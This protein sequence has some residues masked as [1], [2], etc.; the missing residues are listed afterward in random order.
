[1]AGESHG[2]RWVVRCECDACD[3]GCGMDGVCMCRVDGLDVLG[4]R[5]CVM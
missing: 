1:M 4:C 2:L 5:D 3:V